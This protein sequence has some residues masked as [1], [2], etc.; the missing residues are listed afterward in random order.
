[1]TTTGLTE[2]LT[3]VDW[4]AVEEELRERPLARLPWRIA[5]ADCVR[6]AHVIRPTVGGHGAL[7]PFDF[8]VFAGAKGRPG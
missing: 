2:R 7:V 6:L 5:P 3:G 4:R 8:Q 1:M